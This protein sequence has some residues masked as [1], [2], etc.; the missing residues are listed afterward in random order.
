MPK[1][2][3]WFV[4]KDGFGRDSLDESFHGLKCCSPLMVRCLVGRWGQR[5]QQRLE[6]RYWHAM[7]LGLSVG[8]E[9]Y[10]WIPAE[11]IHGAAVNAVHW[12]Y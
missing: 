2:D 6:L 8:C 1:V 3:P 12:D 11:S 5:F 4:Q 10:I 9:V 7:D